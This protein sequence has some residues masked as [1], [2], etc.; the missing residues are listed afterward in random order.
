MADKK[1]NVPGRFTA[2]EAR[3]LILA[4]LQDDR[5]SG[6][7]IL[8][9]DDNSSDNE[10]AGRIDTV[11]DTPGTHALD[12][13]DT[14]SEGDEEEED[15]DDD[16]V[17]RPGRGGGSVRGGQ[18]DGRGGC[19]DGRR[20]RGGTRGRGRV[21]NTLPDVNES[22]TGSPQAGTSDPGGASNVFTS[23]NGKE[24]WKKECAGAWKFAPQ[25]V[26]K[27]QPGPTTYAAQRANSITDT[28]ELFLTPRIVGIILNMSNQEGQRLYN[29]S[30]IDITE[31]ELKAY[32]GLLF[33]AGVY[34]SAG[35]AT[36][37]LWHVSDGR[38]IF[39]AVMSQRRFEDI[40][41]VIRFDD[42]N[43]RS[44]RRRNDRLAPIRD[45][46]DLWVETLSKSFVPY[47]NVT[48]DEQLIPFR[49][50]CSF[51][52]Y[53]K[54]KPAKY[55][56]KLWVMCDS[57][58]SYA[59]NIQVYTGRAA[60]QPPEKNQGERVVHDMVEVVKGTG[61]NVT[62]DNFFTSV[63]LARDL[64]KK[65]LS[66]L[67]TL[68]KNK[69]ELPPEFLP[70]RKRE[71]Y[72]SIF[73]HQEPLTVLSYVPKK[74]K[75]VILLSSM[76]RDAEISDRT[77]KKPQIIMDYNSTKGGVDTLDQMVSKFSTKRMTRR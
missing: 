14:F 7:D 15:S 29:D 27:Q 33:L 65:K 56:I 69:G 9:D 36:E 40:S 42:K 59:L 34:R 66:L 19:G 24:I 6:D 45:V 8:S 32:F 61:R 12:D 10:V 75:A 58:S 21:G 77:D 63:P 70:C 38:K 48:I 4:A 64:L 71:V 28:F 25:N 60:G 73:G 53:M 72:S 39:R 30:W 67:G 35:E 44:A 62:T 50:R 20:G 26:M 68:R 57:S 31:V 47:E 46:F 23:K 51:R 2:S 3:N 16:E 17:S 55:G 49:G 43:T 5:D 41:R 76:H 22:E 18:G 11:P 74:G 13:N 54:S 52:Q 1:R 37:E